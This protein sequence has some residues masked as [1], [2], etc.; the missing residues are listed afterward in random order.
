MTSQE[1][2]DAGLVTELMTV[3]TPPIIPTKLSGT[4]KL[5]DTKDFSGEFSGYSFV[6]NQNPLVAASI[7]GTFDSTEELVK[8]GNEL[9]DA[10]ATFNLV[11][12]FAGAATHYTAG[13]AIDAGLIFDVRYSR[14]TIEGSFEIS[15]GVVTIKQKNFL[16]GGTSSGAFQTADDLF[17]FIEKCL[18][19]LNFY[20]QV[21][22]MYSRQGYVYAGKAGYSEQEI[23]RNRNFWANPEKFLQSGRSNFFTSRIFQFG[24]RF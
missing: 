4:Y 7:S 3:V 16:V 10:G 17:A 20:D 2:V 13:G 18:D 21:Q 5:S 23:E 24:K 1:A 9:K 19:D 12:D 11:D 6:I 22:K 14:T 15:E 8:F